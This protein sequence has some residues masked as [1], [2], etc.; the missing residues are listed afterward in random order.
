MSSTSAEATLREHVLQFCAVRG[1]DLSGVWV[2][3]CSGGR[4]S[5]ALAAV[6]ADVIGG[7]GGKLVLAHYDHALRSRERH[8][9]ERETVRQLAARLAVPL[10][11]GRAADGELR[12]TGRACGIGVEAAAR[13][14]RY[15]FLD[16][17][18][19]EYSALFLATGH[20]AD[21]WAETVIMRLLKGGGPVGLSGI[22]AVRPVRDCSG[23]NVY[24]V[25]RP[26]L[27]LRGELLQRYCSGR[28][29]EWVE[30]QSNQSTE[31][32]RNAVRT[33]VMPALEAVQ[34]DAVAHI[35]AAS[36]K[37]GR[38]EAALGQLARR[39]VR[40]Q[41]EADGVSTS[42][43]A[44]LRRPAALRQAALYH[45]VAL[46]RGKRD[47]GLSGASDCDDTTD[48]ASVDALG[49]GVGIP[50]R[51]FAPLLQE[52]GSGRVESAARPQVLLRGH[53]VVVESRDDRLLVRCD[54]V[55]PRK[56]GYL[57]TIG[58]QF[59]APCNVSIVID[60]AVPEGR[61]ER[62]VVI[63]GDT[64]S[65]PLLVRTRRPGD[66]I[67]LPYGKKSLKKLLHEDG[68]GESERSAVP[69]VEDG[70][71]VVAV[72]AAH[73]AG[74]D[75]FRTGV[76]PVDRMGRHGTPTVGCRWKG[77]SSFHEFAE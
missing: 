69:V 49:P 11:T 16:R 67:Q 76:R 24:L 70:A 73:I 54:I 64:L 14:A 77:D 39:L 31:Y 1:L 13:R 74:R 22:P 32:L 75:H 45:A 10:A 46:L 17:V 48:G 61:A 25:V 34:P 6:M 43:W 58:R 4:D 63:R 62:E 50:T 71:G 19:R 55:R 3:A 65:P 66:S 35:C 12:R 26:L 28:S 57:V 37:I 53:G 38:S 15:G 52:A 8:A 5:T 36:T 21:D 27:E 30:D 60:A 40:W 68:I 29:L 51:F 72:L 33:R 7:A 47:D 2:V 23:R 56:K 59:T 9:A 18:C 44:F 41:A 42:R 20:H